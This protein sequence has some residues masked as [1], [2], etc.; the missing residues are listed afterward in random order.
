[1]RNTKGGKGYSP[2]QIL[3]NPALISKIVRTISGIHSDERRPFYLVR[4]LTSHLGLS[5]YAAYALK[6]EGIARGLFIRVSREGIVRA[7]NN[8]P[9]DNLLVE[10]LLRCGTKNIKK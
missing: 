4:S 5:H 3:N 10:S 7:N 8:A 9:V 2:T 1:M 6:K